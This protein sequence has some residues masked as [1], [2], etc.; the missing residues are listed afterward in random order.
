[1]KDVYASVNIRDEAA[2]DT[3]PWVPMTGKDHN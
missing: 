1:M 3:A 2:M